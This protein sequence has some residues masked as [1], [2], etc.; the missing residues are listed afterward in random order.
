MA[1]HV[2]I[3]QAQAQFPDYTFVKALT[4]SEQKAAFHVRSKEGE[5]LCLKLIA[6]HTSLDRVQREIEAMQ[7]ISHPNVVRLREYT[8]SSKAGTPL[9]YIV[10][11]FIEG[12][13][14]ADQ[15]GKKWPLPQ[16]AKFFAQLADGL[17]ELGKRGVVHR[18]LKPHNIRVR[19]DGSPVIIDFGLARHLHLPDLTATAEGAQIGTPAYFAPEQFRGTKHDIDPRTDLFAL[20][21]MLYQATI[22]S[23]PFFFSAMNRRDL[24]DAVC[25]STKHLLHADFKKLSSGWSMLLDRLLRKDKVERPHSAEHVALLLRRLEKPHA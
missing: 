9:H 5:E 15:L 3:A 8:F 19:V 7:K 2:S 21:V 12:T 13:D 14:L 16:V 20:G 6:P 1:Y 4:P 24:Q 17:H 25:N 22:G 10:E 18:D 11:D 23:H